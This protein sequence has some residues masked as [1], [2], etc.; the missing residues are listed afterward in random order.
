MNYMAKNLPKNFQVS[1]RQL[2]K[3]SIVRVTIW[4]ELI[5]AIR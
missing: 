4:R 3:V 2:N 1:F 5:K